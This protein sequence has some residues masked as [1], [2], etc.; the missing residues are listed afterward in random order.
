MSTHK[1]M[2]QICAVAI[3]AAILVSVALMGFA[4]LAHGDAGKE[5]GYENKLFDASIVHTI[6]LVMDDWEAFLESCESEEYTPCA[7]VIDGESYKNVALRAKGNTSLSSVRQM[8]SQRYSFKIE[9]DHYQSGRT[10]HGLDKLCL[11]NLIQDNTMMKD[12]LVYQMMGQFG[13]KSP[14]CSFAYIRVNGQDW[15][16]YLALEGVEDGFLAR[17]DGNDTGELYKPDSMSFGGGRGNGKDFDFGDFMDK[18]FDSSEDTEAAGVADTSPA[19]ERASGTSAV[20]GFGNSFGGPSGMPDMSSRPQPPSG[21]IPALPDGFQPPE[22]V[23]SPADSRKDSSAEG[24]SQERPQMPGGFGG[25]GM[26]SDDVKLQYIDD[27]PESYANIFN[28]AKTAVT[29]EDQRRLIASLKKLSENTDIESVVD[30]DEVLRYFV[31]HNFVRNGDSYTGAIVHNYYLHEKDGQLSMIPWDY[32]LAFGTFQ[33]GQA[34]SEVN[35]DIDNPVTGANSDRPMLAWIFAEEEYT[36]RYH[37]LFQDFLHSWFSNHELDTIIEQ[38]ADRIR[39]YV[40]SDPTKFCTLEEFDLAVSTLRQFITLRAEAI[41]RQLDGDTTLVDTADLN[42]SAMGSMD[43]GMGGP[44][45]IPQMPGNP[46]SPQETAQASE[47]MDA[48]IAPASSPDAWKNSPERKDGSGQ[49]AGLPPD[50][51][52][53]DEGFGDSMGF[54]ASSGQSGSPTSADAAQ[55]VPP[56]ATEAPAEMTKGAVAEGERPQRDM[57]FPGAPGQTRQAANAENLILLGICVAI[58]AAGLMFAWRLKRRRSHE[59]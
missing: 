24:G 33:S 26:G 10:Y 4:P 53:G 58:L 57:V 50:L 48:G 17:H 36:E 20:E 30:V 7:V 8:G 43:N 59:T 2:D 5:M 44:G 14:L 19:G 25:F 34:S 1:I 31:V 15:G 16:L 11:N 22:G 37:A 6:D 39:R 27:D 3:V 32:N 35:A 38:T 21:D 28:N 42:L 9:F 13:V 46:D 40:E 41:Q 18:N 56:L 47:R 55:A 49:P 54:S 52:S 23:D 29:K 45:G 12:Y 51:P